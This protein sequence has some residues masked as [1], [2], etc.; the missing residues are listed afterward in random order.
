MSVRRISSLLALAVTLF[1][2]QAMA[3]PVSPISPPTPPT[4]TPMSGSPVELFRKLL[5]TNSAGREAW[6]ATRPRA[7][8][9]VVEGKLRE[10]ETLSAAQREARLHGLELRW[11]MRS[12][13]P[14]SPV[15]RTPRMALIPEADR[16]LLRQRLGRWDILP[17]QLK[18]DV[19]ENENLL[20]LVVAAGAS[21]R[22]DGF[23]A[24]SA[25]QREELVRQHER[26]NEL[27]AE[28]KEQILHRFNE[29]FELR[30]TERS[31]LVA[32]LTDTERAQMEQT[33][34]R[35]A[36]LSREEREQAMQ[37]FKKFAEL[38]PADQAAFLRTADR[39]KAMS[40]QDRDLWRRVV[41]SLQIRRQAP[42][43]PLGNVT[44]PSPALSSSN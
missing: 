43:P 28:R 35:F 42:T 12:F 31:R 2:W 24:L 3:Q 9:E 15:E 23:P 34:S 13:M 26:W 25:V 22:V 37:G 5:A 6:L 36:G 16:T 11:Y 33:L 18:K 14:L 44:P 7:T 8:R 20:R 1:E 4:P 21:N 40:E 17:P 32:K 30:D 41:A 27:P 10:Y 19:L 38:S 29:F 39:W